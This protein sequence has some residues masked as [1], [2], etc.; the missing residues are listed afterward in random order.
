VPQIERFSIDQKPSIVFVCAAPR[1]E[2]N[3]DEPCATRM[4]F[5]RP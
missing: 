3:A 5:Q 1:T 4:R 2:A